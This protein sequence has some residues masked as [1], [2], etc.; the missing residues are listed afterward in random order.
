[1]KQFQ[2]R[3]KHDHIFLVDLDDTLLDFSKTMECALRSV[4]SRI[5][6]HRT[7]WSTFYETYQTVN[8]SLWKL[9][10]SGR[11]S[12]SDLSVKRFD[13]ILGHFS[14]SSPSARQIAMEYE[15]EMSKIASPL[16]GAM[17]LAKCTSRY[18]Q[19]VIATNGLASVQ[20]ARLRLSG[21]DLQASL[22]WISG[23]QGVT[24]PDPRFFQMAIDKIGGNGLTPI[25]IGDSLQSEGLCAQLSGIEFWWLN[26]QNQ[27]PG[28][29]HLFRTFYSLDDISDYIETA[30]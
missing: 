12:Q 11:I 1:M 7:D 8:K 24:K 10:E 23:E 2:S 4:Y 3:P 22:I 18:G 13:E 6:D 17:R 19:L 16:P 15:S 5:F 20:R 28:K 25:A 30:L 9:H 21:L 14:I 29:A 27:I 26:R